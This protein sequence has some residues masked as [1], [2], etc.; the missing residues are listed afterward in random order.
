MFCLIQDFFNDEESAF[1]AVKRGK[2]WGAL[3]F[4]ANYSTSLKERLEKAQYA[5]DWILDD[6]L[7]SIWL[8]ESSNYVCR[9]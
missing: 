4:S 6:S 3:S 9:L 5:S 2:A 8:D 7:V 1:E